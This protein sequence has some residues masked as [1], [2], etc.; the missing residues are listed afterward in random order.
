VL[1]PRAARLDAFHNTYVIQE[2]GYELM[3]VGAR[4]TGTARAEIIRDTGKFLTIS[5]PDGLL[6][7][8]LTVD[9]LGATRLVRLLVEYAEKAKAAG[10]VHRETPSSP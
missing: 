6:P 1:L 2:V 8:H 3:L 5:I 9:P 4:V 7:V 10:S